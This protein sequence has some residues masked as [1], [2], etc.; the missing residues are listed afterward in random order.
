MNFRG[1]IAEDEELLRTALSSLLKEA[2]PQL[3]IV[4]ECEDGASALES[5]AELQPDVAFLDI[6]MPGLTGI[7]VARG[8]ADASPRTQV[9]FVTAY[10]QYAIDAFEQGAIDYLLKPITRERLLATV[11]RIQA[12]AAAGHPDGA[13]LEALLRHLSAR[14]MP[15]SKPPLVWITASA[16]K[17]TRLI[18]VDDVAY[19]QADNKYT[20]VMTAEGESLLRTPLRELL[21]SLDAATFKQIHRSTIVNMKAVASVS[22][23]DTGRGRLKL[24]NRPETLTVSQPF[25][26]LFRNM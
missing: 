5:I 18:M 10:D 19:F 9:V 25:M 20:T 17:D 3:Q 15:A 13:T 26:S 11:Q 24:K 6:R 23:D 8:L 22:R 4:A 12:R 14:E 1:V 21:D 16:G 2:W 7:E